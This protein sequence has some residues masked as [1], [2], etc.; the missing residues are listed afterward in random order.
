MRDQFNTSGTAVSFGQCG[1]GDIVGIVRHGFNIIGTALAV[2]APAAAAAQAPHVQSASEALAQD[3]GEYARMTG[4]APDE[5]VRRLRAQQ[6][7]VAVTARI[8][9]IF[10]DRLAGISIEHGPTYRIVVLLTGSAPVPDQSIFASG[11]NV[12]ILFR[13]GARATG[14]QIVSAMVRHREAIR[15]AIPTASGMGLDQ[16][17]GELVLMIRAADADLH[18]VEALDARMEAL[19]GVPVRLRVLDRPDVD[20]G[21][22]GGSRLEGVD[23]ANGRRYACTTGFV[24][25]DGTRTAIVTA[26]HCPDALT[27]HAPGVGE[28]PLSFD[29]QWGVGYQDVQVHVSSYAQLPLFYADSRKRVMRPVTAGRNR[30]STRAGDVVC[31]RGETSG[32]SCSQVDLTDYAPPGDLCGG[33]CDPVWVMVPGPSCKGGDSGGPVFIGTVAFGIMKGA[34]YSLSGACNFYYYM[35]VDYLP[36]GWGLLQR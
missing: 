33:P 7:S 23:P 28:I 2:L 10:R 21:I 20:A 14:E 30:T 24:V 18:G 3:A 5:A 11:M 8:R 15:A 9:Q 27:Y 16:R 22:E 35:S 12:P 1:N 4:V 32:Y 36:A 31:R 19:T 29:G 13:T 25:G 34:N 17:T 26:A 6:E